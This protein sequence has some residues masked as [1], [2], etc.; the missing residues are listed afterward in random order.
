M[1]GWILRKCTAPPWPKKTLHQNTLSTWPRGEQGGFTGLTHYFWHRWQRLGNRMY[2]KR[3]SRT[4]NSGFKWALE[5]TVTIRAPCGDNQLNYHDLFRQD[6]NGKWCDVKKVKS[7]IRKW[8]PLPSW[9]TNNW[10]P[11]TGSRFA[12]I[13]GNKF[14]LGQTTGYWWAPLDVIWGQ[15]WAIKQL[16]CN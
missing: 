8:K 9:K 1:T 2:C 16:S 13:C 15:F 6:H 14:T 12:T 7:S 5:S 4:E 11:L 10:W 3:S